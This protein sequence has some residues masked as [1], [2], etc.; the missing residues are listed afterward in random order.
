MIMQ[1]LLVILIALASI[2]LPQL[3]QTRIQNDIQAGPFDSLVTGYLT[4]VDEEI[5]SK[6]TKTAYFTTAGFQNNA[7]QKWVDGMIADGNLVN[8]KNEELYLFNLGCIEDGEIALTDYIYNGS[9]QQDEDLYMDSK[10]EEAIFQSSPDNQITIK[11]IFNGSDRVGQC[12][13]C[14]S[15][16][17]VIWVE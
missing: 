1:Q 7:L 9:N 4:T 11:L 5:W 2:S 3:I 12:V 6:N 10:T 17:R 13:C 14:H 16:D 15:A 8:K